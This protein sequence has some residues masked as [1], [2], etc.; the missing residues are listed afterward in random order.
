MSNRS[1]FAMLACCLP[2]LAGC[3]FCTQRLQDLQDAVYF[4][5][6][7]GVGLEAHVSVMPIV[8]IAGLGYQVS[9]RVGWDGWQHGYWKE[10]EFVVGFPLLL[11]E[12]VVDRQKYSAGLCRLPYVQGCVPAA[13][14]GDRCVIGP[15]AGF[16]AGFVGVAA[17]VDVV[18]L[19]DFMAGFAGWDPLGDD[20]VS[21]DKVLSE[22][23]P[24]LPVYR[25]RVLWSAL[26][27]MDDDQV[28]AFIPRTHGAARLLTYE[29]LVLRR[30][31]NK[32]QILIKEFDFRLFNTN[33]ASI[34][35][36]V[37]RQAVS[38]LPSSDPAHESFLKL[39]K[40]ISSGGGTEMHQAGAGQAG[41]SAPP[42]TDGL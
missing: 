33:E 14:S 31:P 21:V 23:W 26:R 9:N 32:A 41:A 2:V 8:G 5:A 29:E 10:S 42:G 13:V 30:V 24:D 34:A 25:T 37:I 28:V 12:Y 18:Q 27:R 38:Q 11:G 17:G 35:L 15:E 22:D 7:V 40:R 36:D 3:S 6:G 4:H 39:E 20:E 19:F 1:R 16:F